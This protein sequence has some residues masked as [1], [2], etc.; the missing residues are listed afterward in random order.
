MNRETIF[1]LGKGVQLWSVPKCI[2][3]N[4]HKAHYS[5][6]LRNYLKRLLRSDILNNSK[7][8][9]KKWSHLDLSAADRRF[10]NSEK[11]SKI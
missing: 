4:R 1:N 6:M 5:I 11:K 8:S 9:F 7:A 3:L 2:F 10:E